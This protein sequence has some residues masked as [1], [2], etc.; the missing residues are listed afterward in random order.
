[1]NF[2]RY[3]RSL[4]NIIIPPDIQLTNNSISMLKGSSSYTNISIN[5]DSL[6]DVSGFFQKSYK[7]QADNIKGKNITNISNTYA[8]C[9]NFTKSPE[10]GPKVTNMSGAY[11]QCTEL[12]GS[13]VCGSN[14]TNMANAYY[15][16]YNLTGS[17]VCG[18][19]VTDMSGAYF[20]C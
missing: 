4:K 14:V 18:D 3:K 5:H 10:C 11:Y 6:N 16:C 7:L 9:N 15:C 1:M 17:P 8:Y 13:P 12:T 2:K 19:K 20:F